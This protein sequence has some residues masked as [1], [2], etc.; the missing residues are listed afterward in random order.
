MEFVIVEFT[1]SQEVA[2]IPSSWTKGESMAFWP[3]YKQGDRINS[4]VRRRELVNPD[5]WEL[6]AIRILRNYGKWNF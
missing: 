6:F 4:A 1:Q 2:V 5:V 3:P